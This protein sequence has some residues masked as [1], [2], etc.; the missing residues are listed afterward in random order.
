[1]ASRK[2]GGA[3]LQPLNSFL[4]RVKAGSRETSLLLGGAL[5]RGSG[6]PSER[7][8]VNLPSP[9]VTM[10]SAMRGLETDAGK[11]REGTATPVLCMLGI[12]EGQ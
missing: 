2:Q 5:R 3:Q 7:P 10:V 6:K 12:W 11:G 4:G 9:T 8:P 1:M